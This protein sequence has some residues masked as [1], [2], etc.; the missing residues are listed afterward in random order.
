[1]RNGSVDSPL[2]DVWYMASNW[3]TGHSARQLGIYLP[4]HV[5]HG[6]RRLLFFYVLC[7]IL[8]MFLKPTIWL[9]TTNDDGC[10]FGLPRILPQYLNGFFER[11]QAEYRHFHLVSSSEHSQRPCYRRDLYINTMAPRTLTSRYFVRTR[12]SNWEQ[13]NFLRLWTI[14]RQ[15]TNTDRQW[16]SISSVCVLNNEATW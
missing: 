14:F 3:L 11:G 15:A 1:M 4:L 2:G 12:L 5:N 10:P 16:Y 7:E 6:T 13:A 8:L 9:A